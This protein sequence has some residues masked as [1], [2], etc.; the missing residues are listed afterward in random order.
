M[1]LTRS[2][3]GWLVF[4]VILMASCKA[5]ELTPA[6]VPGE[7]S[8]CPCLGGESG[9]QTCASDGASLGPCECSVNGVGGTTGE[10]GTSATGGTGGTA[11]TDG[12]PIGDACY[13]A[14][15]LA[16]SEP[17]VGIALADLNN[18]GM[19]DMVRSQAQQVGVLEGN[20]DGTFS[21]QASIQLADTVGRVRIEQLFGSADPEI[22]VNIAASPKLVFASLA[23]C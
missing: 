17:A 1:K 19:A 11:G 6:C 18:D 20:G 21:S 22:V 12:C 7:V 4:A 14:S 15:T 2:T 13:E 8:E 10:G 9:V 23:G 5:D 3:A 16:L